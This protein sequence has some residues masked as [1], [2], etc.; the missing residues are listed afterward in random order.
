MFSAEELRKLISGN[1]QLW[2]SREQVIENITT[3]HGYTMDSPPVQYLINVIAEMDTEDQRLFLEF[4]TGT[5][6]LPIDG[7]LTPKLTI[8][9]KIIDEDTAGISNK[10]RRKITDDDSLL[11]CN[12]CFHL[13]KLPNYSS[14]ENLKK[15]LLLSIRHGRGAFELS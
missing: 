9:R 7:K 13:I 4:S 12:T 8:A 3:A 11:S 10:N 5:T 15:K 14:Q 2:T 1:D 6:R